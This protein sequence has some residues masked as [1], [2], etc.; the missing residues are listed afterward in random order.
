MTTAFQKEFLQGA[1]LDP[2]ALGANIRTLLM[3][4][5]R[6]TGEVRQRIDRPGQFCDVRYSEL[7]RDPLGTVER[8][9]SRFGIP[10]TQRARNAMASFVSRGAERHGHNRHRYALADY[11]L[12]MADIERDFGWYLDEYDV[13][14]ER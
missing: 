2:A 5:I 8:I 9:Y 11:G 13:A 3:N 4:G 10:L 6:H 12:S 1:T 7:S 14:R